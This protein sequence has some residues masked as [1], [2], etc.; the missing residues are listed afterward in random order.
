MMVWKKSSSGF[1]CG[2]VGELCQILGMLLLVKYKH[3]I[4]P[5]PFTMNR[6][7]KEPDSTGAFFP[8]VNYLEPS[9][10]QNI[11]QK[12]NGRFTNSFSSA[13]KAV[14]SQGNSKVTRIEF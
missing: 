5:P 3:A 4:A 7:I 2:Y 1:K 12:L 10:H 6:G 14:I 8:P 9:F 13:F 11:K